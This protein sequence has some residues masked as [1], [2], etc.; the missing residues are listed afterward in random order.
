MS[1]ERRDEET[2]RKMRINDGVPSYRITCVGANL[3]IAQ[4]KRKKNSGQNYYPENLFIHL[5]EMK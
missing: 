4:E 1:K 5:V 3:D 2:T